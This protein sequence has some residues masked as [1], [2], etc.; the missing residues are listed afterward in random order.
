MGVE[1]TV[2]KGEDKKEPAL[3]PDLVHGRCSGGAKAAVSGTAYAVPK[4]PQNRQLS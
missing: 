1:Q 3:S 4:V 2:C